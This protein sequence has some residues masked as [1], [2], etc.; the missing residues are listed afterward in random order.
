MLRGQSLSLTASQKGYK[1][2]ISDR[3]VKYET[4]LQKYYDIESDMVEAWSKILDAFALLPRREAMIMQLY[5]IQGKNLYE[6]SEDLHY[7]ARWIL[8][9]KSDALK[10][11]QDVPLPD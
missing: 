11:L 7:S 4:L 3:L 5:Y 6:I 9:L 1:G 8:K 10:H 2:D